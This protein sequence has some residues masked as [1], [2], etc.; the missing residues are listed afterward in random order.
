MNR[1]AVAQELVKLAKE[2]VAGKKVYRTKMN[3]G[4]TKYVVDFHDGKSTHKDGSEFY[5]TRGFKNK[6]DFEDFQKKLRGQGYTE[7]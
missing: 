4:K 2:L 5:D 6:E 3:I 7:E 1:I